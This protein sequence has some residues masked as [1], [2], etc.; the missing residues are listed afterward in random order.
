VMM[1]IG[2]GTSL[3]KLGQ[4]KTDTYDLVD[5]LLAPA[6]LFGLLWWGGFY[7]G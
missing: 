4:P 1:L 3:A 6:M 2:M 5:V 7:G